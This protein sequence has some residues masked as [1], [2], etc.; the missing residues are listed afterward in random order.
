MLIA[1][2]IRYGLVCV[3]DF[4]PCAKATSY[5]GGKVARILTFYVSLCADQ[6]ART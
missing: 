1:G 6:L 4:G 2:S 3:A 5:P